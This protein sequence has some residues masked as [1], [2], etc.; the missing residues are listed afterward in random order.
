MQSSG[1]AWD[2]ASSL[3]RSTQLL[4]DSMRKIGETEVIGDAVASNM[5]SQRAQLINAS[6]KVHEMRGFTSDARAILRSMGRRAI[7]EKCV[8]I[9]I[10]IVLIISIILV[11]YYRFL[12]GGHSGKGK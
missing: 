3:S 12:G 2:A 9:T 7:M 10:I 6:D 8:L 5:E 4:E 1:N 11:V